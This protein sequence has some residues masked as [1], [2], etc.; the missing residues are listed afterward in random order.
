MKSNTWDYKHG[1]MYLIGKYKDLK[2][3]NTNERKIKW[4][5]ERLDLL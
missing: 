5:I 3:G 1:K 4:A 2:S